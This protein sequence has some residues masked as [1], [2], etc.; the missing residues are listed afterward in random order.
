MKRKQNSKG[1][2][3]QWRNI[4]II[5]LWSRS[6]EESG[7]A[8]VNFYFYF[9][10]HFINWGRV[11]GLMHFI[12]DKVV[13]ITTAIKNKLPLHV[14]GAIHNTQK[15]TLLIWSTHIILLLFCSWRSLWTCETPWQQRQNQMNISSIFPFRAHSHKPTT[16]EQTIN[17]ATYPAA[18]KCYFRTVADF[19]LQGRVHTE[20]SEAAV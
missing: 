18:T 12:S 5:A 15:H 4:A 8:E 1:L 10:L 17:L 7:S 19:C 6:L 13:S 9:L 11:R 2:L 16:H 3:A 20:C 14:L